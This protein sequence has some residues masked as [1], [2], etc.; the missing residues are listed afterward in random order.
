MSSSIDSNRPKQLSIG[1]NLALPEVLFLIMNSV[2][3]I[4]IE[5]KFSTGET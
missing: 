4:G 2:S 1:P 3:S 5:Y